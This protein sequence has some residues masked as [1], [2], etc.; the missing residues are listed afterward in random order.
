MSLV[1]LTRI[2]KGSMGEQKRVGL[3][4]SV[5]ES[6]TPGS[7]ILAEADR[8]LK[9]VGKIRGTGKVCK[10]GLYRFETY[11]EADQWMETMILRSSQEFQP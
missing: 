3:R 6:V 1:D 9:T 2:V 10:R 5:G 4:R 7:V 8:W 11:E